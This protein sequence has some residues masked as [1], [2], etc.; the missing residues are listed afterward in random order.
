MI[1]RVY[2]PCY[3]EEKYMKHKT[4]KKFVCVFCAFVMCISFASTVFAQ[5]G[6]MT[7]QQRLKNTVYLQNLNYA[8]ACDGVLTVINK[9]DKTVMPVFKDGMFYVPLRFILEYYGA[10]VSW[11]HETKTVII[12]A[13]ESEYRLDTR[14][15]VLS[16]GERKRSLDNVCFIDKGTTFICFDDISDIV[17]C[18]TYYFEEYKSGVI[19]MGEE[20]NP[21][22]EAEKEA[23]EAMEFALSPFFKMFIK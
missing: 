12:T 14:D 22:R 2:A 3:K 6:E 23:L 7:K 9:N 20:W 8:A 1:D 16:M 5:A 13:G 18:K 19:A 15:S 17:V 10:N 4:L 11:E 21:E